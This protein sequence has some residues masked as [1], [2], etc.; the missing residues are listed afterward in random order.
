MWILRKWNKGAW[1]G[2][3]WLR[4]GR[5]GRLLWIR[6]WIVGFYKSWSLEL[7]QFCLALRFE[8]KLLEILSSDRL[9]SWINVLF[10]N[11]VINRR[12]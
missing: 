11:T 7:E 6:Q 9:K 2:L 4:T 10:L 8:K 12:C 5:D 1:T 3:I